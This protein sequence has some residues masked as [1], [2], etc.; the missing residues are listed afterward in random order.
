MKLNR[1][2]YICVLIASLITLYYYGGRIPYTLFYAFLIAPFVSFIYLFAAG[3]QFK[4]SYST[5]KDMIIKGDKVKVTVHLENRSFFFLP[6]VKIVFHGMDMLLKQQPRTKSFSLPPFCKKTLSF[7]MDCPFRG[8]YEVGI[9]HVEFKDFFGIIKLKSKRNS[10]ASIIVH[11]KV[12]P[13]G[14]FLYKDG[15]FKE[16]ELLSSKHAEDMQTVSDMRKYTYGDSYKKIHWKLTAKANDLIV[17]NFRQSNRTNIVLLLDLSMNTGSAEQNIIIEDKLIESIAA[18]ANYYLSKSIPVNLV[19]YL[20]KTVD[21]EAGS[22]QDFNQIYKTLSI[23]EFKGERKIGSVLEEYLKGRQSRE[24]IVVFTSN[25]SYDLYEQLRNMKALVNKLALV[26]ISPAV[27]TGSKSGDPDNLIST[28][29]ESGIEACE[30]GLEEETKDT[31]ERV[32][33]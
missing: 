30:I 12:V 25:M 21:I 26:Y 15:L 7:E 23:V 20:G 10:S 22:P 14:R 28:L 8:R 13:L 16:S 5:D 27:I 33:G 32:G 18:A 11:P 19:Y 9:R 3:F 1:F 31:L 4:F 29:P 17:K 2:I 24:N 6:Y